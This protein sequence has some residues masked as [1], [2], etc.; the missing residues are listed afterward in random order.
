MLIKNFKKDCNLIPRGI[1]PV[2]IVSVKN[3]V[4]VNG[5]L[6]INIKLKIVDGDYRDYTV[7]DNFYY[8]ETAIRRFEVFLEALGFCVPFGKIKEFFL[9]NNPSVRAFLN[10]NCKADI[11]IKN[12]KNSV[13]FL[14]YAIMT[15][16]EFSEIYGFPIHWE[17]LP[18]EDRREE[19]FCNV[20]WHGFFEDYFLNINN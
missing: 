9:N 13:G 16:A 6:T 17:E 8:T 4:S 5:N 15:E 10:K 3:G 19:D 11:V 1:Y 20:W 14:G 12:A 2:E 7:Y 18:E